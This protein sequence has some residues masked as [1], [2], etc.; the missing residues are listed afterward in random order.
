MTIPIDP[1]LLIAGS[2]FIAM[3]SMAIFVLLYTGHGRRPEEQRVQSLRTG[4]VPGQ[5]VN[6]TSPRQNV[7]SRAKKDNEKDVG[8]GLT[9]RIV[10]AGLY[11]KGSIAVFTSIRVGL[12]ILPIVMGVVIGQLGIVSPLLGL[13]YGVLAGVLGTIVPSFWLDYR[14]AQRQTQ[15]RRALPDALDVIVTCVDAGLSLPAAI[16]RVSK[17]LRSTHPMLAV[18]MAICQREIQLGMST[19]NALRR[20]SQ[21][22]DLEELRSLASV[23]QQAEKFGASITNALRVHAD[24]LREKR[25]QRAEEMAQKAAVKIVF[26]TILCIFPALFI[27]LAG[28]AVTRIFVMFEVLAKQQ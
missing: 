25:F 4:D 6:A 17:E 1:N 26:P 27:V 2:A 15:I 11:K 12:M 10:Q 8:D 9:E 18:E 14:K 5:L 19:G 3:T 16:S 24:S 22:F 23:I 7:G 20:F 28:P 13:I 21:R